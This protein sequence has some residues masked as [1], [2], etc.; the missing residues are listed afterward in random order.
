M[1]LHLRKEPYKKIQIVVTEQNEN[2]VKATMT[3][4][5]LDIWEEEIKD[6]DIRIM[7][8][9]VKNLIIARNKR[10]KGNKRP[11]NKRTT[12]HTRK[13]GNKMY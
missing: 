8:L 6:L 4:E 2:I 1:K 7:T 3:E 11:K 5:E 10:N 13:K 9:D 12:R